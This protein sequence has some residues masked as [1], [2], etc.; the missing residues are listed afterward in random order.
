[1][2]SPARLPLF[3]PPSRRGSSTPPFERPLDPLQQ[4]A[5][6]F[7]LTALS[8]VLCVCVVTWRLR[9]APTAD[10]VE[11][12]AVGSPAPL[13]LLPPPAPRF[14]APE[15]PPW[16]PL[17]PDSS[18]PL[19]PLL[20]PVTLAGFAD[21]W[22]APPSVLPLP[23]AAGFA[24]LFHGCSHGGD[25]WATG[26]GGYRALVAGLVARKLLPVALTS[27]DSRRGAAGRH[28]SHGC[29]DPGPDAAAAAS[30][31]YAVGDYGEG[32]EGGGEE[33][34]P[35]AAWG[36]DVE[37]TR[38]AVAELGRYWAASH[39]ATAATAA[40]AGDAPP[41]PP[42]VAIGVSSGGA[43]VSQLALALPLRAAALYVMPLLP[44]VLARLA[45]GGGGALRPAQLAPDRPRVFPDALLFLHMPRDGA[46][47]ARV[48]R[49]AAA[50]RDGVALPLVVVREAAPFALAP[51][52]FTAS[53]AQPGFF[54]APAARALWDAL[55]AGGVVAPGGEVVA[56]ARGEA[57]RRAVEAVVGDARLAWRECAVGGEA[58][59]VGGRWAWATAAA[60]GGANTA[61]AGEAR[62]LLRRGLGEVLAEAEGGHE[63]ISQHAAEVVEVLAGRV[64]GE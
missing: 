54:P 59:C 28:G 61:L 2:F 32:A 29:W 63:M 10:P 50:L 42:L 58:L 23:A 44:G 34:P 26:G 51:A 41:L 30:A 48:E 49:D 43:F 38:A 7:R 14:P 24:L 57:A 52:N 21:A 31:A 6:R 20:V 46:T 15:L 4:A 62:R 5:L 13:P 3:P 16:P 1:M 17:R 18:A 53:F 35:V 39:A 60:A 11:L 12:V 19:S 9:Y 33:P 40:A 22:A 55:A 45:P 64:R 47:R 37:A 25:T 8:L 27:W 36:E 56:N